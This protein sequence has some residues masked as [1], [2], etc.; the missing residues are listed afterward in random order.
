MSQTIVRNLPQDQY[1]E[2]DSVKIRYWQQGEGEPIILLHG[3]NSCIEI[4]SFN[5]NQLAQHYRVYAFDMVG[6][7]RSDKPVADYSLDYQVGFLRRFMDALNITRPTLM[8]NSMGGAIALKF[9]I[10]FP[11][12]VN[13]LILVSSFA[14]GREIDFFKRFLAIFPAI[15]YLSKPSRQGA[16]AVLNSCVYDAKSLPS[17][18]IELS[19]E[20]FKLPGKKRVIVSMI[21]THFNFWGLRNEVFEPIVTQL[22]NITAPTLIFWGKQDKVIPAKHANIAAEQIPNS[23]LHIFDCCGHW[24]QVKYPAFNQQTLEFLK[25]Q[26]I[27]QDG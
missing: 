5:I 16:K 21:K 1:I 13:K 4:W 14:L 3:G 20:F 24:A 23:Y 8:G 7:G 25:L 22:K 10:Q 15:A 27:N 9:A 6:A 26:D 18:W 17:E 2:L 12:R 19:Y 11:E